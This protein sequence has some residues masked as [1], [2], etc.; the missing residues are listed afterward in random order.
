MFMTIAIQ[1][2]QR[3]GLLLMKRYF[4]RLNRRDEFD[5]DLKEM[6]VLKQATDTANFFFF[7]G[8]SSIDIKIAKAKMQV[9]HYYL[10]FF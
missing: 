8:I 3:V 10:A 6:R 4:L 5:Q 7:C 1:G 2:F 9:L